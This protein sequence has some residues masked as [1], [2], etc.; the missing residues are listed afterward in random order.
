MID[1]WN[2]FTHAL[3][4]MGLAVALAVLSYSD[5]TT[6]CRGEGFLATLKHT[7]QE[8]V[9]LLGLAVTCLGAGL[10]VDVWWRRV[11]WFLLAAGFVIS[12]AHTYLSRPQDPSS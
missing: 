8:P 9:L 6:S 12:M 1:W 7:V 4:I 11:L 10:G 5:W 2:V 3:W